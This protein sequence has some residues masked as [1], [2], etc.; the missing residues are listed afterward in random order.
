MGWNFRVFR[1]TLKNFDD[2]TSDWFSIHETYYDENGK[3]NGWTV[4]AID[5]QGEGI[6]ELKWTLQKM[7]E[8]LEKPVL[9]YEDE[10]K[11][12]KE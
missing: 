2:T 6:E 11:R 7:L 4:D 12:T 9:E 8:C 10:P 3:P 5:L 1:R